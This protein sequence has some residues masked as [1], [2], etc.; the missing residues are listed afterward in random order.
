MAADSIVGAVTTGLSAQ[1]KDLL[2]AVVAAINGTATVTDV[3]TSTVVTGVDKSGNSTGALISKGAVTTGTINDGNV[4][5][6][7]VLPEKV[8]LNFAGPAK[9]VDGEAATNYFKGLI[10]AALPSSNKSAEVIQKRESLI[11]AVKLATEGQGKD[12][13]VRFVN[14]SSENTTGTKADTVKLSGSATGNKEVLAVMATGLNKDQTLILENLDR[15]LVVN[16]AKVQVLGG[17]AYVGGD[18]G[19]QNITGG[20]GAD[21]LVGGGGNDTLVGGSGADNFVLKGGNSLVN[22]G[23][24]NIAQGDKLVFQHPGL[25]SIDQLVK[26]VSFIQDTPTG[27]TVSFG[28]ELTISL[29]GVKIADI[30]SDLSF[31][32]IKS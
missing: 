18:N 32:E 1:S 10:D 25:T 17:A 28:N 19:N 14:I 15:V 13:A 29:V 9:A 4:S 26:A 20:S 5:L 8:N 11:D 24:L 21:T 27:L 23:D 7:V 30:T 6:G 31:I 12:L 3:G 22:V 2:T 16:D